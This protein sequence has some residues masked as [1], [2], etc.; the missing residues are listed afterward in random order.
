M[1]KIE[2]FD[3]PMCCTSG[4]CGPKVDPAL[5]QFAADLEWFKRQ[6]L[7]VLRHNL[8]QEPLAF[9]RNETVRE[10]LA[11][12]ETCLP[13]VLVNGQVVSRRT[14]PS[15]GMLAAAMAEHAPEAD[16]AADV[17]DYLGASGKETVHHA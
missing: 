17:P 15:A 7:T 8:A 3:L 9:A 12:D 10:A 11:A 6:G 14:Y 2:V 13:L 1:T 4:V 16:D 5:V